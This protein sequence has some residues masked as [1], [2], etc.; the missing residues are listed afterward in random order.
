M[1]FQPWNS[2]NR[3]TQSTERADAWA[4]C[5]P[6]P[7]FS[8]LLSD[9]SAWTSSS[10][11]SREIKYLCWMISQFQIT[12]SYRQLK[13]NLQQLP[14]INDSVPR[15]EL[16]DGGGVL[17]GSSTANRTS[18]ENKDMKD[19]LKHQQNQTHL[20]PPGSR[21][22]GRGRPPDAGLS[23]ACVL[24]QVQDSHICIPARSISWLAEG[25]G[26]QVEATPR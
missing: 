19:S 25:E 17:T 2:F 22:S 1:I 21:G 9:S 24:E 12:L 5:P 4:I 26:P 18:W 14:E 16:L 20:S 15:S 8:G 7:S 10:F 11:S 23:I 13:Q 6:R 3:E